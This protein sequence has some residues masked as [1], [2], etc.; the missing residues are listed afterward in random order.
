MA[1]MMKEWRYKLFLGLPKAEQGDFSKCICVHDKVRCVIGHSNPCI[2]WWAYGRST[3]FVGREWL[4]KN[5]T[6]EEFAEFAADRL[7]KV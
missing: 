6:P 2:I 5:L 7:V 4:Q 1:E 3:V